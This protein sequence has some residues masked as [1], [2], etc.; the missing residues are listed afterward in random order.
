MIKSCACY[1][2]NVDCNPLALVIIVGCV[3]MTT[4]NRLHPAFYGKHYIVF[5]RYRVLTEFAEVHTDIARSILKYIR[6][7]LP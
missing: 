1:P 4:A 2:E 6:P 5:D 3:I 7:L